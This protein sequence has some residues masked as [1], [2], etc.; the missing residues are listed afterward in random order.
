MKMLGGRSV[1][2]L[3]TMFD[4]AEVGNSAAIQVRES[5]TLHEKCCVTML[6]EF[7]HLVNKKVN[8]WTIRKYKNLRPSMMK[9]IKW[10]HR[11]SVRSPGPFAN[12]S[13]LDCRSMN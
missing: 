9:A 11:I 1:E 8:N 2:Q 7:M 13:L 5:L 10:L 4:E 12:W 3:H 6:K